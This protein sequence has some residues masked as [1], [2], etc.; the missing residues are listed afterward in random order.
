M[1]RRCRRLAPLLFLLVRLSL[2]ALL[3]T[4]EKRK[5]KRSRIILANPTSEARE[6]VWLSAGSA[7]S[8]GWVEA[9]GEL[10]LE[11]FVGHEIGWSRP[12]E[13]KLEESITVTDGLER[14]LLGDPTR[15]APPDELP[16]PSLEELAMLDGLSSFD[17]AD[18]ATIAER[19]RRPGY[20]VFRVASV[21]SWAASLD[22]DRGVASRSVTGFDGR[23]R[24]TAAVLE[25]DDDTLVLIHEKG[26]C[27]E[28]FCDASLTYRAD[29]GEVVSLSLSPRLELPRLAELAAVHRLVP[30]PVKWWQPKLRALRFACD[31]AA[32]LLA[33]AT[34]TTCVDADDRN[35]DLARRDARRLGLGITV[36]K[37]LPKR[38][39]F[40]VV[41][42][43]EG[44]ASA[45]VVVRGGGRLPPF[46][47]P[48]GRHPTDFAFL[49]NHSHSI[50]RPRGRWVGLAPQTARR[51]EALPGLACNASN[52][53]ADGV[54]CI[55]VGKGRRR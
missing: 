22:D 41:Y 9:Y 55:L 7:Q 13:T 3:Q 4:G 50:L 25:W 26:P 10:E 30:P 11:T 6:V 45:A 1:M 16:G 12:N 14:V 54:T 19:G 37:S 17:L 5:S 28:A 46:P 39:K 32:V 31:A 15:W 40:D 38:R 42:A 53:A 8:V 44:D 23:T 36:V 2:S 33:K 47:T 35:R 24:T 34:R 51:V 27:E 48:A 43:P 49:A 18:I 29:E 20:Y 52:D 21:A